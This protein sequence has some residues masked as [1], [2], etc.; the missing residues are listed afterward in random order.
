MWACCFVPVACQK[1]RWDFVL[2]LEL[3]RGVMK[4]KSP[5]LKAFKNMSIFYST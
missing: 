2:N 5:V 1:E 3:F 4:K